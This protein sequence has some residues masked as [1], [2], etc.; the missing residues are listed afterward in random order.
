MRFRNEFWYEGADS[1]WEHGSSFKLL[2]DPD[3]RNWMTGVVTFYIFY[4]L[5]M[6]LLAN[7]SISLL[8]IQRLNPLS[9]LLSHFS[10][11]I[12]A[13]R[14]QGLSLWGYLNGYSKIT[15]QE[16]LTQ[17]R[18]CSQTQNC[19]TYNT[20]NT[21]M[22]AFQQLRE[23]IDSDLRTADGLAPYSRSTDMTWYPRPWF[24]PWWDMKWNIKNLP[25]VGFLAQRL[26]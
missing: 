6:I 19:D 17:S 25:L 22:M 9:F 21:P 15:F 2:S 16:L 12:V 5:Q 18:A 1:D 13:R 3:G 8:W 23:A 10:N 11:G 26:A 4:L 24:L 14:W 7:P 20:L